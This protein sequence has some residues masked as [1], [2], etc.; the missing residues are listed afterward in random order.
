MSISIADQY[1]L[2]ANSYYPYCTEFVVE[3]LNY[4]LSYEEFHAPS[5]VLMGRLQMEL[6]SN[7]KKARHYFELALAF[8]P[9]YIETYEHYSLL[10][11]YTSD[12]AKVKELTDRAVKIKGT[13]ICLMRY[14]K[15]KMY[16]LMGLHEIAKEEVNKLIKTSGSNKSLNFYK[17]EKSRLKKLI[18]M[19]KVKS[20]A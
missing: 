7:Y 8:E 20:K 14:R 12:F 3:N 5:L 10:S 17:N 9:A 6:L 15:V 13:D 11:L 18:K 2:K 16:E 4:A 1:F 19:R